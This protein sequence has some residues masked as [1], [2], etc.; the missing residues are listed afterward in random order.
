MRGREKQFI[1]SMSS[2]SYDKYRNICVIKHLH[3]IR[4]YICKN[5]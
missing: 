3:Q 1:L 4:I 5:Y 2:D